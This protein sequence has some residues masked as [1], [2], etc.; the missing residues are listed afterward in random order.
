MS[1]ILTPILA[2]WK[3]TRK[4]DPDVVLDHYVNHPD[5]ISCVVVCDPNS[6]RILGFQSLKLARENND[7]DLPQGCGIIGTYV[8]P[9][10]GRRGIGRAMF[11]QSL[12]AAQR[13]NLARID[14]TIGADNTSGQRYYEAVGFCTYR[15]LH[16][17]V[18]KKFDVRID[19]R[20][21]DE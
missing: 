13:A 17:A 9:D 7:Y 20:P 8:A 6:G 14:A 1:L 15:S 21:R 16:G 3:S 2:S 18:G 10:A 19:R 11:A 5:R 12:A 4:G